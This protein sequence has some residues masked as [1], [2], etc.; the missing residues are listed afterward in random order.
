MNCIRVITAP[1]QKRKICVSCYHHTDLSVQRTAV[2]MPVRVVDKNTKIMAS[3]YV[4]AS[5]QIQALTGTQKYVGPVH[6]SAGLRSAWNGCNQV[7]GGC[8]RRDP[9]RGSGEIPGA[10]GGDR[11]VLR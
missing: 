6:A 4:A 5:I 3:P 1:H 2:C 7:L 9:M 11:A 10:S 8:L